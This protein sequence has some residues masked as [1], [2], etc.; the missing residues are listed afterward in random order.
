MYY[1]ISQTLRK[2]SSFK[3]RKPP[4]HQSTDN[5]ERIL[6]AVKEKNQ[7]KDKGKCIKIIAEFST[8]FKTKKGM[9]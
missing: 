6:K 8:N 2:A 1:K 5:N 7:I 9:E 4:R 3:Y